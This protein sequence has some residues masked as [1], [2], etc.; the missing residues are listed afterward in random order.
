ML[1]KQ[2]CGNN[3]VE[4]NV[5]PFAAQGN[6]EF[7]RKHFASSA[8]VSSFAHRGNISTNNVSSTASGLRLH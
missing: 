8:N 3:V 4:A 5:S 1:R 7:V 6:P 2:C